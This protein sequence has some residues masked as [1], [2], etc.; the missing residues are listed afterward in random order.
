MCSKYWKCSSYLDESVVTLC[1][2]FMSDSIAVID[3]GSNSIKLLVACVDEL[4]RSIKALYSKTIEAR[5]STGI[6]N[7]LPKLAVIRCK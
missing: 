7:E 3:V 5:I 4:G 6:N 2:I 1:L